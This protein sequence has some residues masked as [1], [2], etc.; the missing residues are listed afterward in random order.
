MEIAG[1]RAEFLDVNCYAVAAEHPEGQARECL[2]VDAGFDCAPRMKTLLDELGWTP[3]AVLLTHGHPDHVLGLPRLREVFPSLQAHLAAPDV[4][5]LAD[6]AGTL[7]PELGQML[8]GMIGDW[9]APEVVETADGACWQAAGLVIEATYAPGHTEGSTLWRVRDTSGTGED[10][11]V[12]EVLFTGDVLFAGSIGRTD[13]PG[14]DDQAMRTSLRMF[15]SMPDTPILPGH[16]PGST[17]AHELRT[18]P[19]L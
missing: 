11:D 13:L 5:R 16:G 15:A 18:N 14:G 19:F 8:G 1:V 10:L 4:Y 2:L 3:V 12:P 9:T 17:I 6:P 7:S